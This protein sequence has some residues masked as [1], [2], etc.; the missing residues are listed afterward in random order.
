MIQFARAGS[1]REILNRVSTP[2]SPIPIAAAAPIESAETVRVATTPQS[3]AKAKTA[4]KPAPAKPVAVPAPARSRGGLIAAILGL[5]VVGGG[6]AALM[7]MKPWASSAANATAADSAPASPA[8]VPQAPSQQPPPAPA[9][10]TTAAAPAPAATAPVSAPSATEVAAIRI[11]GAPQSLAV[12]EV[13]RA[14]ATPVDQNNRPVQRAGVSWS[15]SNPRVAGVDQQGT[16]TALAEGQ[17]TISAQAGR[18]S[19]SVAITVAPV[20]VVVVTLSPQAGAVDPGG[21]IALTANLFGPGNVPLSRPVAWESDNTSV[22]TVSGGVVVARAPG[23]ATITAT[24]GGVSAR[25][26]IQVRTPAPVAPAATPSTPANSTSTQPA[27]AVAIA[28]LV[29]SY[30]AALESKNVPRAKALFPEMTAQ[31][32]REARDALMAMENLQVRLTAANI[33]VDGDQGRA[34]V[35]GQWTFKGG[36]VDIRNTYEFERRADGWKIVAIH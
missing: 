32:E 28:D 27:P 12:G 25:A 15:S 33:T 30:A 21:Q 3:G 10:T 31:A 24:S 11:V 9:E 20:P 17:V 22:A 2:R 7:V 29:R 35:T 13:W 34:L 8:V 23:T 5:V 14:S 36:K 26:T 16:V 4:V 1:Q 18:R 6:G 19:Q